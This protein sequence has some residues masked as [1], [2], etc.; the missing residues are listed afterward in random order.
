MNKLITI[1][2]IPELAKKILFTLG[3]LVIYRIGFHV[4]LPVIDQEKMLKTMSGAL[5]AI[6]TRLI[7]TLRRTRRASYSASA[8]AAR[9]RTRGR[10][11]WC[12]WAQ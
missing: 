4:P 9:A 2:K 3:M 7:Q 8:R 5:A 6:A 11:R 12:P 10:P 1:F